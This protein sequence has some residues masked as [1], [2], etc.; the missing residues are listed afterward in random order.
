VH[1]EDFKPILHQSQ[2][3][4]FEIS[5][6]AASLATLFFPAGYGEYYFKTLRVV[7][8]RSVLCAQITVIFTAFGVVK[9]FAT[10][11]AAPG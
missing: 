9:A 1:K 10:L 5:F 2:L 7:W 11:L 3:W 4:P 8:F 6:L